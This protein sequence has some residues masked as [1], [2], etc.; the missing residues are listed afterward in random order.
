MPDQYSNTRRAEPILSELELYSEYRNCNRWSLIVGISKYQ[1]QGLNL[2]YAHRDAEEFYKLLLTPNGGRFEERHICKL[3][4]EQATTGKITQAL[5]SFLQ[6]PA[7]DDLVIVYFACHGSPDPYRPDNLY[8]L[9]HDTDPADIAGTALPMREVRQ[10]VTENLNAGKVVIL[11]DTCHSGG[12]SGGGRRNATDDSTLMNRYLQE[13]S[14]ATKGLATFTSAEP[15][16]VAQEGAR[17]GGGHGVFTYYLLEGMRGAAD[18]DRNGIITVG[19]LFEYVRDC[20]KRDTDDRQH[21]LISS[22]GFDRFLPI[23]VAPN[24]NFSKSSGASQQTQNTQGSRSSAAGQ[25]VQENLDITF[26]IALTIEEMSAGTEKHVV[27]EQ[28]G[29]TVKIPAGV[30]PGK[31]IRVRGKGRLN[32]YI[33]PI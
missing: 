7:R 15:R 26:E 24:S 20:V 16:Q 25:P 3:V 8:L 9:T 27:T 23:A 10:A 30:S 11:A 4:N 28:G 5:R 2:Q 19:E 29:I 32:S 6:K 13:L 31:R 14:R 1:Y 12:I 22:D 21:P 33:E 17:W 18:R